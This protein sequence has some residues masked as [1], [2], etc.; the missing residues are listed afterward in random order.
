MHIMTACIVSSVASS[1]TGMPAVLQHTQ[2]ASSIDKD[3]LSVYIVP[4]HYSD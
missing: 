2:N 3:W 1:N 4:L